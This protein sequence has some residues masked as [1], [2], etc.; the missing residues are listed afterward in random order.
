M[1]LDYIFTIVAEV[2]PEVA[3]MGSSWVE[4]L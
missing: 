2:D 3:N 1:Y 4:M